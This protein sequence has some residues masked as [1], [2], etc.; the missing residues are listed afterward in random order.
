[1]VGFIDQ[2]IGRSRTVVLALVFITLAGISVYGSIPKE[3]QPDVEIPYIYVSI[4]HDGI[5]PEDAER[6]L[7]RPMEQELRALEGVKEMTA[8]A[9]EGG[10]NVTLEFYAGIDTDQALQDVREKTDL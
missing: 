9:Y 2:A 10:A 7:V 6:L 5:S 1:M 4:S 3:A 8:S